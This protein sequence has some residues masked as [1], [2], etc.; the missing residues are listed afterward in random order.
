LSVRLAPPAVETTK[1][2][3]FHF[4][5]VD[6][7]GVDRANIGGWSTLDTSEVCLTSATVTT[8]KVTASA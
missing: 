8:I 3:Y 1:I 7:R 2:R 5:V 6:R 4:D